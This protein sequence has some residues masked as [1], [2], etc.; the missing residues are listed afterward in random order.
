[1]FGV[2]NN[3]SIDRRDEI[4]LAIIAVVVPLVAV[5]AMAGV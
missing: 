2:F 4:V 5:Y 3:V 1:M